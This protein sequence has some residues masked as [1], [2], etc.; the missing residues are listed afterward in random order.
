MTKLNFTKHQS[1]K[2]FI[3]TNDISTLNPGYIETNSLKWVN[4]TV[5]IIAE[6]TCVNPAEFYDP[7]TK[8]C[9]ANCLAAGGTY[10]LTGA[11]PGGTNL[12]R[13]CHYSC[14]PGQ[15]AATGDTQCNVCNPAKN[16]QPDPTA[17]AAPYKC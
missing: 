3:D 13:K 2:W 9:I 17:A 4:L 11:S 7:Q 10:F 16:R 8:T 5:F 1:T 14:S 6:L 12:C 15:C